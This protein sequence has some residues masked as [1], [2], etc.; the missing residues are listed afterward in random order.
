[1]SLTID[2]GVKV[3]LHFSLSLEDGQIIDSNFEAQPATFTMGD[4]NLL[5][6]FEAVL[7]GLKAGDQR[8]FVIGPTAAFGQRNPENIQHIARDNFDQASL[9][10]GAVFSFQN[11]DGELPG[12]VT[13]VESDQVTVDFNHPL[14][15]HTIV[16]RVDI[17]NLSAATV[18]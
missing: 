6:G 7:K 2:T 8:E 4:G 3:T 12:V 17:V 14:S 15:G 16:F 5:P 18:H 9:Q 11:G 13:A 1:M 10:A